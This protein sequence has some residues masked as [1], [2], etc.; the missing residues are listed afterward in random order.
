MKPSKEDGYMYEKM[1]DEN[2][3]WEEEGEGE[4][5]NWEEEE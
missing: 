4:N 5:E 1:Y 2:E 3:E